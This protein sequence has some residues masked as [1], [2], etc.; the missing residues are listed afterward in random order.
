MMWLLYY[1]QT[2]SD[3]IEML[4]MKTKSKW[5]F[6]LIT[7]TLVVVLVS[8]HYTKNNVY[9]IDDV[10]KSQN[11]HTD[12]LDFQQLP[13]LSKW[14]TKMERKYA[15]SIC[16]IGFDENNQNGTIVSIDIQFKQNSRIAS[17]LS[18]SIE[19]ITNQLSTSFP[20]VEGLNKN[21]KLK[22]LLFNY[23]MKKD[24]G[25][26]YNP[27]SISTTEPETKRCIYNLKKQ[28]SEPSTERLIIYR[29]KYL[30]ISDR[31][32][33]LELEYMGGNL[34]KAYYFADLEREYELTKINSNNYKDLSEC[35]E[36]ETK[37][38]QKII[39]KNGYLECQRNFIFHR[40]LNL[41][42]V[43]TYLCYPKNERFC[44]EEVVKKLTNKP[45]QQTNTTKEEYSGQIYRDY[46]STEYLNYEKSLLGYSIKTIADTSKIP[47]IIK[48]E[49]SQSKFEYYEDIEME[50][51]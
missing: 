2:V 13:L 45:I 4:N 10:Y 42:T 6:F 46:L 33:N 5:I 23:T 18:D 39:L 49:I 40:N 25:D 47:W 14:I 32:N 19:K 44:Y 21:G 43:I 27:Y 22:Y 15:C 3:K 29:F 37:K 1:C 30:E 41:S 20:K 50:F 31:T 17:L 38:T 16:F 11:E 34:N 48:Y 7:F 12:N 28:R 35:E 8:I 26:Y 51:E 36:Y 9:T 24:V